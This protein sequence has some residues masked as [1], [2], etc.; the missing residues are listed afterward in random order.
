[1]RFTPLGGAYEVGASCSLP[2][3]LDVAVAAHHLARPA[4]VRESGPFRSAQA[5]ARHSRW[6]D[7]RCPPLSAG[8]SVEL[9]WLDDVVRGKRHLR[10]KVFT[11]PC[12]RNE[13]AP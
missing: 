11:E 10:C 1:M 5:E 13:P 2:E 12:F 8:F 3:V 6:T 7:G 4:I 9:S